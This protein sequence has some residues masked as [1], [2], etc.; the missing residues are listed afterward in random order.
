MFIRM[1]KKILSILLITVMYSVT[2]FAEDYAILIS[3]GKATSD[4]TILNSEYWYDLYL[5]YEYLLLEEQYDST[6]VFVFYGDGIDFNTANV[7]YKKELHNWGQITDYDN[8][9]STMNSI[10]SLLDNVIT[11][12]DNLLFYWI[13]GHGGKDSSSDDSYRTYIQNTN[14]VVS[15]SQLIGLINSITHYNRRK[16]F[17]MTCKSG[18]MGGG[19]INPN[20]NKTTL[21][22][23]SSSNEDSYSFIDYN[24]PHSAFNFA[25]FSLS[26]G[27]F[28]N[29]LNCELN[30]V[31]Y[32]MTNI[33]SLLSINELYT[34]IDLFSYLT[35]NSFSCPLVP[36]MFDVGSIS[37]KI[38]VGENKK[39]RNI[40][41]DANSSYWIDKME[42]SN[43]EIENNS[44]VSIDI[45]D[46]CLIK[47]STFV[48]VGSMLLIK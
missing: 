44:N 22:T 29:G 31:C 19:S 11:D 28:V 17:W 38:F 16:I 12:D 34:G 6:N 2:C 47:Q 8:S 32:G 14:E 36:C 15:K 46:N 23:S 4:N 33:D 13:A 7:R 30:Q 35:I 43:V 40:T 26:T 37:N 45:D 21:V 18:A 25:L 5:T 20:N 24:D 42:I 27:K 41:I 10:I 1:I 39:M 48:D 9:Y 3:A